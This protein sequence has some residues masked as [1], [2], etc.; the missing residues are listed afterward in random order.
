[1]NDSER[2]EILS[3]KYV[4]LGKGEDGY[5]EVDMN[6]PPKR[7][8][9]EPDPNDEGMDVD[10]WADPPTTPPPL[11]NQPPPTQEPSNKDV[12][13]DGDNEASKSAETTNALAGTGSHETPVKIP[14]YIQTSFFPEEIT[15]KLPLVFYLSANQLYKDRPVVMSLGVNSPYNI[16]EGITLTAQTKNTLKARGIS[17]CLSRLNTEVNVPFWNTDNNFPTVVKGSVANTSSVTSSGSVVDAELKP[18]RR[19]AYEKIYEHYTT[20]DCNYTV[21]MDFSSDVSASSCIVFWQ[22]DTF[23]QNSQSDVCP[24]DRNLN[25]MR[26]YP[27]MKSTTFQP[28]DVPTRGEF[29]YRT[30]ITGGWKPNT[31][32]RNTT[33]EKDIETWSPVGSAPQNNYRERD[34]FFFYSD[35]LSE[36]FPEQCVNMRIYMEWTVQFRD[37]KNKLRYPNYGDT[38]DN[39]IVYPT[40]MIQKPSTGEVVQ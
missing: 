18:A 1:M 9:T 4:V 37:I 38:I 39:L 21:E 6:G 20:L 33:N 5:I 7:L 19:T 10:N 13:M 26:S 40:D 27:G 16:L 11:S 36:S 31:S 14:R 34:V 15:V 30:K 12:I 22:R 23:T 32:R 28:R 24:R 29:T 35:W 3:G 2:Q 25:W 17:N 8:R